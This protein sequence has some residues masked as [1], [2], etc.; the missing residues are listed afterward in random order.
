VQLVHESEEQAERDFEAIHELDKCGLLDFSVI[1]P[2]PPVT[3]AVV[4]VSEH[5]ISSI[6]APTFCPP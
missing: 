3:G 5:R 1:C 2:T 4:V 6:N